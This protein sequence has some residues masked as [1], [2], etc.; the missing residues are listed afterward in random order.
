MKVE[1][2]SIKWQYGHPDS[3][4]RITICRIYKF[5]TC[6]ASGVSECAPGDPFV[7]DTG[8]KISLKRGIQNFPKE[9][10]TK[11]WEAYLNR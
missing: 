10:R 7:K 11:F 9:L 8:R 4:R 3:P 6:I 1:D 2:F 5:D